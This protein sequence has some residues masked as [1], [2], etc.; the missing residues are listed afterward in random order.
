MTHQFQTPSE[1]S[2]NAGSDRPLVIAI[3][4]PS[5]SGKSSTA[6]GV[7]DKLG[8]AFLDTGAMYRAVTWLALQK[9]VDLEDRAAV[10]D[11]LAHISMDVDMDP[12]SPA[13]AI[14]G[15]DV[16]EAIRAPEVSAAVSAIATNL[17][18]RTDLV[19]RQKK[20]IAEAG[21]IVAEGRDITTVVAPSADVR[22]LLVA[23]PA[24]RV[25]RRHAELAEHE[26]DVDEVHDQVIRRDRDD[27]V[28]AQFESA[29]PGVHVVD[30]TSLSLEEVI[31]MICEFVPVGATGDRRDQRG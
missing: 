15:V 3:D 8:L 6:R 12:R 13:I 29:A 11:L 30:S 17:D 25:A 21:D 18:V 5:G 10:A 7:A 20:L 22:V 26:I 24:A 9:G 28:V 14:N 1:S 2:S 19:A 23:D 4:G 31:E 16:T 27:S